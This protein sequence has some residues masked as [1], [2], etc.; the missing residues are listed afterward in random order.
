M[1]YSICADISR[2]GSDT[3]AKLKEILL[4]TQLFALNI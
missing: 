2:S 1:T 4:I 3:V